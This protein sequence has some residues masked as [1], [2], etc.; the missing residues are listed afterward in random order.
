MATP[1]VNVSAKQTG[2]LNMEQT[3][4]A[5][6]TV[7]QLLNQDLERHHVF[8]NDRG[9]HDHIVHHLL[10]LYGSGANASALAAAYQANQV[11]QRRA[12]QADASLV[13]ALHAD[14]PATS[15]AHFGQGEH[16]A[17]FLRFFQDAIAQRGAQAVAQDVLFAELPNPPRRG[18]V[19]RLYSGLVHP[20]LQLLYG[21]EWE[22]PAIVAAALAQTAVHPSD[23]GDLMVGVDEY[24][25]DKQADAA[26]VEDL[27]HEVHRRGGPL[28]Q[29][30][31]FNDMGFEY[32][33]RMGR[34]GLV[35]LLARIRVDPSHDL[36]Q[37]TARLVHSAAY[38]VAAAAWHPPHKPTFDFFLMQVAPSFHLLTSSLFFLSL[39]PLSPAARARLIEWHLRL[40]VFEYIA[41]GCPALRLDHVLRDWSAPAGMAAATPRHLLPR[42]L[43]TADDGHVVKVARALVVACDL[44]RKWQGCSWIR[45]AGHD[46]WVKLMQILL[47]SVDGRGDDWL[48]QGKQWVRGAGFEEAWEEM[49]IME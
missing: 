31:S 9:F 8:Y 30:A 35:A 47:T 12:G 14:W 38:L 10:T 24:S 1:K 27:C 13:A 5:A 40:Q 6:E 2:L 3:P 15:R 28:A 44:S 49:P 33:E 18:M 48:R 39:P 43:L 42:L 37:D 36:D 20:L 11:V 7:S 17:S 46:A 25:R 34:H 41:H 45:I 4:E 22:Q 29:A 21:L 26:S 32:I 23:V 16:Y 19:A